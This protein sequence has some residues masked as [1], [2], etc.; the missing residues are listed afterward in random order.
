MEG[1][2]EPSPESTIGLRGDIGTFR[3][4]VESDSGWLVWDIVVVGTD[5]DLGH[6]PVGHVVGCGYL[7]GEWT[8]Q[9]G[10]DFERLACLGGD[11]PMVSVFP[12]EVEV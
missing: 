10:F 1:E 2:E 3:G 7:L 9:L 12:D 4:E 8:V 11:Y 6:V 5:E